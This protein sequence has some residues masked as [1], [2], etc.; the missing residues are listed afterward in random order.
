MIGKLLGHILVI[1]GVILDPKWDQHPH[2]SMQKQQHDFNYHFFVFWDVF[3]DGF[4]SGFHVLRTYRRAAG[5]EGE[6]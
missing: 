5:R 4:R 2:F 6:A 1:C 3:V